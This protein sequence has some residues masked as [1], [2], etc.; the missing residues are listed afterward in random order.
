MGPVVGET[1]DGH[2][3]VF[4]W[5]EDDAAATNLDIVELETRLTPGSRLGFPS[6][7]YPRPEFHRG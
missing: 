6:H 3:L 4:H 7:G 5:T 2:V 1:A